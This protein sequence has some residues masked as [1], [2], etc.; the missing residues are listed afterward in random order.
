MIL[1]LKLIMNHNTLLII[2]LVILLV[3]SNQTLIF[4]LKSLIHQNQ[5][6]SVCSGDYYMESIKLAD[7][8][9]ELYGGNYSII[10]IDM[11]ASW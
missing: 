3:S 8:N 7:L 6:F 10:F 4:I 11:S 9:G 2:N 1:I 5:T